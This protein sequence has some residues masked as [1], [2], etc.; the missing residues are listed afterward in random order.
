[1]AAV[2]L[3]FVLFFFLIKGDAA[4]KS[5]QS[6]RDMLLILLI[7]LWDFSPDTTNLNVCTVIGCSE[8]F[9]NSEVNYSFS[10]SL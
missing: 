5:L 7:F 9:N 4:F 6:G 8:L 2:T 10:E 3:L 1:M